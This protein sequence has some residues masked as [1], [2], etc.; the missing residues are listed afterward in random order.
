M[1]KLLSTSIY[2]AELS[3][4]PL[5]NWS[6]VNLLFDLWTSLFYLYTRM[7]IWGLNICICVLF[8]ISAWYRIIIFLQSMVFR[9]AESFNS[10]NSYSWFPNYLI[11]TYRTHS[12][13]FQYMSKHILSMSVRVW[14]ILTLRY[15]L[16]RIADS[17][18]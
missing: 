9:C 2:R 7:E 10:F 15:H 13:Y 12:T 18:I 1:W 4:Y 14:F 5:V 6:L 8:K 16:V 17:S 11:F 3:L